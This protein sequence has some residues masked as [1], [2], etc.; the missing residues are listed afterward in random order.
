MLPD[1]RLPHRPCPPRRAGADH[2]R[3]FRPRAGRPR[4]RAG[5]AR[6]LAH[7]GGALRRG[8]R[9]I[10]RGGGARRGAPHRRGHGPLRAGRPR[11]RL[12]PDRHRGRRLPDRRLGRLQARGRPD[13]PPV[14]ARALRRV[15]HRGDVRPAGVPPPAG[16]RRDRKAPRV[17]GAV[18]GARP[19]RRRLRARQGAARHGADP[20]RRARRP[21]LP[22]RRARAADRALQE[23]RHRPR[24]HAEG[25]GGK[26]ERACRQDRAG[27]ALGDAG[28]VVAAASGSR[29]RL[30]LRL[31]AGA[32]AGPPE[33]R[34]AA[35]RHLRPRRL[36]R[37]LRHHRRDRRRRG[38]GHARPGG[39]ARALVPDARAA[40]RPLH[41]L[42]YG[43][44]EEGGAAEAARLPAGPD[45]TTVAAGPTGD[46]S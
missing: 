34:R 22:A 42:G 1:G 27:P 41:M 8:L 37:P 12:G 26:E 18:P 29:D 16:A 9:R 15:H 43:D 4:R 7:H 23:R 13:L 14:R 2:A 21:D 31:D 45:E 44:E 5:D 24:R 19:S 39:R 3:P 11:A 40:A 38:L 25:N 20:R 28:S 33:G 10:E 36:G 6:D 17:G 35:A 46:S 30:R 32:G